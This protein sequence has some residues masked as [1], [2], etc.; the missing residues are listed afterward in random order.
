MIRPANAS[1]IP[2]LSRVHVASWRAAYRH[3]L[4]DEVLNSLSIEQ[5]EANWRRNFSDTQRTNLVLEVESCVSGFIAFGNSRDNDATEGTGEIYA[6]YLIPELWSA[7]YGRVLWA[8]ASQYLLSRFSV[9]TLWVLQN[10][11][12]ARKFYECMGLKHDEQIKN[13]SLYGVELP[14]VRYRKYL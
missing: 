5:F 7:G 3:I 14:E 6:L 4:P 12:R 8:E 10:N 2:T 1:D 11:N 9:F 13:I